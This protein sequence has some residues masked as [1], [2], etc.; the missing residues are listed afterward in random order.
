MIYLKK[1]AIML[2]ILSLILS[3]AAIII[4][5]ARGYYFDV[6]DKELGSKGI[7][8]ANSAPNNAQIYVNDKF[9]SLT[10]DNLYLFSGV[11]QISL[12]YEY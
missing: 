4:L 9:M 10:S 3:V 11:Y 5:F 7:L 6:Q 1:T 12:L 8:V 2:A